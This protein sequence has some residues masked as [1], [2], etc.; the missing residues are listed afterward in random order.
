MRDPIHIEECRQPTSAA[1]AAFVTCFSKWT[2]SARCLTDRFHRFL[3][4]RRPTSCMLPGSSRCRGFPREQHLHDVRFFR[5]C[6]RIL[7][8]RGHN[9]R[10]RSCDAH[11]QSRTSRPLAHLR[12]PCAAR[13][14]WRTFPREWR[15]FPRECT[16]RF[17]QRPVVENFAFT[18]MG[19]FGCE[20]LGLEVRRRS[21]S[22]RCTRGPENLGC[23]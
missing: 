9:V 17:H 2:R 5:S 13:D 19:D 21:H 12:A 8:L 20:S 11:I 22:V 23:S 7:Y 4:L 14:Y 1:S 6:V 16:C 10:P 15:T 18:P 3:R